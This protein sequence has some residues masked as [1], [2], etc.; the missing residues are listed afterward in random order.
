LIRSDY[1]PGPRSYVQE[2]ASSMMG[3]SYP[4]LITRQDRAQPC[5]VKW[6]D[7]FIQLRAQ[8]DSHLLLSKLIIQR[9]IAGLPGILALETIDQHNMALE[10]T[11]SQLSQSMKLIEFKF[12]VRHF[13]DTSAAGR[14]EV[15]KGF[16]EVS[17]D[18][19]AEAAL[20][21]RRNKALLGQDLLLSLV[22]LRV[23]EVAI[24]W[25]NLKT[26]GSGGWSLEVPDINQLNRFHRKTWED[27]R[28]SSQATLPIIATEAIIYTVE[29][30]GCEVTMKNTNKGE[31]VVTVTDKK[32][33]TKRKVVKRVALAGSLAG[34]LLTMGMWW[35][36]V[37]ASQ[38]MPLGSTLHTNIPLQKIQDSTSVTLKVKM[39]GMGAVTGLEIVEQRKRNWLLMRM[40]RDMTGSP[41]EDLPQPS[42]R[43]DK[44]E[45]RYSQLKTGKDRR[46][47]DLS[48]GFS[49]M[50]WQHLQAYR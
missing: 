47:A 32:K 22:A 38:A 8:R 19:L 18:Q 39:G 49:K 15:V 12:L 30:D 45:S 14:N 3:A 46:R 29:E 37:T 36:L 25:D 1:T 42:Q 28:R 10:T 2:L 48:A 4:P 34:L 23:Q 5:T 33:K 17:N 31:K 9:K 11:L 20:E 13:D 7:N 27:Y 21:M 40:K 6:K 41:R 16:G 24:L 50:S 44:T 26:D 43:V 35:H